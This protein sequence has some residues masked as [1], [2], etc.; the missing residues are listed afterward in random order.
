MSV[1]DPQLHD[2]VARLRALQRYSVLDTGQERN[3]DLITELVR[4]LLQVPICAVSLIDEDRQWFKSKQG[5][6]V[7][8]TPRTIAFCDH[9]IR[10]RQ[11]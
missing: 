8:E 11:Y 7:K 5:L 1:L 10:S 3:F 9:T 2:E 4:D 6:E